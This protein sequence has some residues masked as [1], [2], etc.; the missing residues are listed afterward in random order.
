MA[1]VLLLSGSVAL[2]QGRIAS[3][4][5]FFYETTAFIVFVTVVI[6]VYLYRS[7]N[8][9][10]FVQLYLLSMVVKLL[11][12]FA[13]N[14]FMVLDDRVGAVSNVSYFLLNYVLF[15]I[16]EIAF[17]YRKISSGKRP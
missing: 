17:L 8:P 7:E 5:S 15:T 16:L 3:L 10:F 11:A 4:P 14:I 6:F 12:F 9:S 1:A 13:Y 2:Q